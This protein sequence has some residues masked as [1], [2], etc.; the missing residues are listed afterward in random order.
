MGWKACQWA[1][2]SSSAPDSVTP[3][4]RRR[5]RVSRRPSA[6]SRSTSRIWQAVTQFWNRD[7]ALK[8]LNLQLRLVEDGG[9]HVTGGGSYANGFS[10]HPPFQIDGNFGFTAAVLRGILPGDL[11]SG[12]YAV[13]MG[14][15]AVMDIAGGMGLYRSEY[16]G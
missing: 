14:D 9:T 7:R 11:V 6:Q 10:A 3:W 4:G 8:L 16:G 12:I 5:P 1:R 2:H 13:E 15:M